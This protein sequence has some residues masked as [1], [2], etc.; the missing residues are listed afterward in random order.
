MKSGDFCEISPFF[1]FS[2]FG[3]FTFPYLAPIIWRLR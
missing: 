3:L 1:S 2:T